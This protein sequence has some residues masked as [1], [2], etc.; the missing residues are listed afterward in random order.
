MASR[1]PFS[2]LR[3]PFG[4]IACAVALMAATGVQAQSASAQQNQQAEKAAKDGVA[5][6]ELAPNA[7][8]SYT[9]KRGDTLWAISGMFLKSPWRWPELWGMNKS[10]IKDPHWIYPGQI[11]FLD[12]SGGRARL[13]TGK[14]VATVGSDGSIKLTPQVRISKTSDGA[15][16]PIPNS[17]IEPFLNQAIIVDAK[18]FAQAPRVVAGVEERTL[19]SQGDRAYV[20]AWRDGDLSMKPGTPLGYRIYRNA[21]PLKDP[22]TG[23][24]LAYEAHYLA[25]AKLVRPAGRALVNGEVVDADANGSPVKPLYNNDKANPGMGIDGD[26][27]PN[28]AMNP[29]TQYPYN[30]KVGEAGSSGTADNSDWRTEWRSSYKGTF[31][32]SIGAEQNASVVPGTIDITSA[33]EEV[34]VGDRLGPDVDLN[35]MATYLPH[36]A[37]S[38]LRAR[39]VSVYSGEA[40][41]GQNQIVALNK[42]LV[43]GVDRGSVFT[44]LNK[45]VL[46][47]DRT[48]SSAPLLRLPNEIN[49]QV[50]VFSVF[51]RVSYGLVLQIRNPVR[52]GDMAIDPNLPENEMLAD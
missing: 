11:L 20:R 49:G 3:F 43:D 50:M 12:K 25:T 40:N 48:D 26:G 7:P 19:F 33:R 6:S 9:V 10:Q 46:Q 29:I 18:D 51:D 4:A 47:R 36:A 8:D 2:V 27:G 39:I 35:A 15:I 28:T 52:V 24:I 21:Q 44:L 41:G 5:L 14:P 13:R 45:G 38:E 31:D 42:G 30:T 22:E 17:V 37:A 16:L 23:E 1:F 34:N 32:N